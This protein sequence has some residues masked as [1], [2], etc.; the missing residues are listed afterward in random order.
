MFRISMLLTAGLA[1]AAITGCEPKDQYRYER[2][3]EQNTRQ[4]ETKVD[5]GSSAGPE[6]GDRRGGDTETI[7]ERS[8]PEIIV[9]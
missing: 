3:V 6:K 5:G 8:E 2:H 1:L 4:T 7:K 9:E